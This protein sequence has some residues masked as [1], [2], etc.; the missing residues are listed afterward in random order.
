MEFDDEFVGGSAPVERPAGLY[1]EDGTGTRRCVCGVS[2]GRQVI[3]NTPEYPKGVA[4]C[5]ALAARPVA[6]PEVDAYM[7][8]NCLSFWL[9]WARARGANTKA[10]DDL[11]ASVQQRPSGDA[12]ARAVVEAA[13]EFAVVEW[14]CHAASLRSAEGTIGGHIVDQ[15]NRRK[16]ALCR[17]VETYN[18]ALTRPP[19]ATMET[20]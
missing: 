4:T 17:A 9:D 14:A 2:W 1:H 11:L 3:R 6:G 13:Q 20:P 16:V 7:L 19:E 8:A 18:R 5:P 15:W 12:D 10:G